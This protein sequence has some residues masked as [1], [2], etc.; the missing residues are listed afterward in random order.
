MKKYAIILM[1]ASIFTACSTKVKIEKVELDG[2]YSIVKVDS[3]EGEFTANESD[4]FLQID[5]KNMTFSSRLDCNS[6]Q[7]NFKK[8]GEKIKLEMTISTRMFCPN[9]NE[10]IYISKLSQV[11]N[12]K[13]KDDKVY[14][15][16]G[17][18]VIIELKSN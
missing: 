6:M 11:D 4:Y 2:R 3:I 1:I 14:L 5:N 18:K 13:T 8:E 7:G 16:S 17:D 9:G 10:D 12:Y 15:M